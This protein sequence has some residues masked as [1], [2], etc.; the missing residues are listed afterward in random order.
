MSCDLL[1]QT[2]E[3]VLEAHGFLKEFNSSLQRPSVADEDSIWSIEIRPKEGISSF[4][5]PLIIATEITASQNGPSKDKLRVK[6]VRLAH[7]WADVWDVAYEPLY[8]FVVN[9]SQWI[10]ANRYNSNQGGLVVFCSEAQINAAVMETNEWAEVLKERGYA[11]IS[12]AYASRL[13]G[14][15]VQSE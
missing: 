3:S 11:D 14:L 5:K 9:G 6:V 4:S 7:S 15:V 1:K 13:S 8:E 2:V 10:P 12:Q